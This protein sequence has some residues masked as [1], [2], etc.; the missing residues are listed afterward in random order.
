VEPTQGDQAPLG[1]QFT[2]ASMGHLLRAQQ[3]GQF[4]LP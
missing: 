2:G 1:Q 3:A 4:L